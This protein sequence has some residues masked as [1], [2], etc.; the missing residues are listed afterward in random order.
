MK[1]RHGPFGEVLGKRRLHVTAKPRQTLTV[2][3]GKPRRTPGTPD[4]E[5]PF[6][7]KGLGIGRLGYGYGV[8]AI[9]ALVGALDGI[10]VAIE[11]TR[12]SV[13]WFEMPA[14]L[15]FPRARPFWGDVAATRRIER[16][17]DRE[18]RREVKRLEERDK[19][20]SAA[21]RPVGRPTDSSAGLPIKGRPRT[22]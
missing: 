20:R 6:R 10:R 15:F 2:S 14:D 21:R 7:V 19:K 4:W 22:N 5:C 13:S 3:L 18:I 9:Q 17:V 16:L 11:E 12:Q 1:V 8:D